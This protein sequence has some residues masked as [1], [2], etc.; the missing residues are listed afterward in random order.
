[1]ATDEPEP[2]CVGR[3]GCRIAAVFVWLAVGMIVMTDHDGA[4]ISYLGRRG[5][6]EFV[7]GVGSC[8]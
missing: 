8:V 6:H 3:C 2:A 4:S 5:L 7:C 1:M